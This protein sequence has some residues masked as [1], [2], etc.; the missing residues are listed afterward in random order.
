MLCLRFMLL[1]LPG[2]YGTISA[3]SVSVSSRLSFTCLPSKV[4]SAGAGNC[5]H[6]H[7]CGWNVDVYG[8]QLQAL[9]PLWSTGQGA[10]PGEVDSSTGRDYHGC[11]SSQAV[12]WCFFSWLDGCEILHW[13]LIL[14]L[15]WKFDFDIHWSNWYC[16][17]EPNIDIMILW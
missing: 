15:I 17:F 11:K 5:D 7:A 12:D 13:Y 10:C 6:M 3:V 8:R 1:T 4:G 9:P 16:N 14:T 2:R